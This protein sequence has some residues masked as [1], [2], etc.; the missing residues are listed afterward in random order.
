M[1]ARKA[2]PK[3][4]S[5][6]TALSKCSTGMDITERQQ[7]QEALIRSEQLYRD[8]VALVD[9]GVTRFDLDGRRTFANEA[10][11]KRYGVPVEELLKGSI[12]DR[13]L[14]DDRERGR[15]HFRQCV[16]TGK[17]VTDIASRFVVKGRTRYTRGNLTPIFGDDGKVVGVQATSV[18]ITDLMEAQEA[19]KRSEELYRSLVDSVGAAVARVDRE[20]RRTFINESAFSGS[21]KTR[22][23]MLAGRFGD[24]I[25]DMKEREKAWALLQETFQTGKPVRG[26]ISREQALGGPRY[27]SANWEPIRDASGN[28]AEVQVTSFDITE[29][30][31]AQQRLRESEQLYR[32]I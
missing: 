3:P 7:D 26:F 18:D 22:E 11:V 19:L 29:L 1:V 17:P 16:E 28:V 5:G 13:K 32:D 4:D 30:M 27:F 24:L 2:A 9:V 6:T 14:S 31:E 12:A 8:I 15:Q 21:G 20:G 23:E 25:V 10:I